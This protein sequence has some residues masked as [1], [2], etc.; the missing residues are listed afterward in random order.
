MQINSTDIL[1]YQCFNHILYHGASD[2][3]YNLF[4]QWPNK[5]KVLVQFTNS[6]VKRKL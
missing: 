5:N 6:K 1:L 3:S 2:I 4:N